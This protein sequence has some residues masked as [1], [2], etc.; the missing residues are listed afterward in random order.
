MRVASKGLF[1]AFEGIDGSGKTVQVHKLTEWI[2]A[3]YRRVDTIVVTHEPTD[4]KFTKEIHERA[5]LKNTDDRSMPKERLLE[6]FVLDR[7]EHVDNIII[8]NLEKKAVVLCDRYKYST[9][10]YQSAQGVPIAHAISENEEFPT[11]DLTFIFNVSAEKAVERLQKQGKELD[12]FI[13]IPFLEKVKEQYL[14]LPG[15]LP[16][17]KI[18]IINANQTIEQIHDDVKRAVKPLLDEIVK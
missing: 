3:H 2:F 17:E 15:L 1:I 18:Q 10:A 4:S 9:I 7:S 6:L 5:S 14:K 8:P 16:K 13:K 12:K 11:P